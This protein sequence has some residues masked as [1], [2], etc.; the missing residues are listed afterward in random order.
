LQRLL[1]ADDLLAHVQLL[2]DLLHR[3]V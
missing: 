3:L 2:W 1:S